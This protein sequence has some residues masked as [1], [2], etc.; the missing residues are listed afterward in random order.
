[1]KKHMIKNTAKKKIFRETP[2]RTLVIDALRRFTKA[3]S[4]YDLQK[5][6]TKRGKAINTVTVYRI[7]SLLEELEIVHRH[8]CNGGYSLCTLPQRKGHHGFL[9]CVGCGD[10]EEFASRS[11]CWAE[12]RI[13]RAAKFQ[14]TEH[15][16]EMIGMCRACQ[17]K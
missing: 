11:L 6:I 4:P 10:I 5:A 2:A 13:A 8:P 1:M 16:S 17:L 15:V 3:V 12:N 14:A 9:H 7:L